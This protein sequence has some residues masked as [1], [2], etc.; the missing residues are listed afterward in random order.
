MVKIHLPLQ[1]TWVWYPL[2][3]DAVGQLCLSI[4]TAEAH[5]PRTCAL[6]QEEPLLSATEEVRVQQRR[7]SRAKNKIRK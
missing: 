4:T 7:P 5:V 2:Q 6:Q 1:G 3:E